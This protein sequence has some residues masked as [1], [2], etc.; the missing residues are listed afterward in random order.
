MFNKLIC[1]YLS[2][3]CRHFLLGENIRFRNRNPF[4]IHKAGD[5][6]IGD[7]VVFNNKTRQNPVGLFKKTSIFIGEDAS[8]TIGKNTG[9]SGVSI[10]CSKEIEI[11]SYCNIGGNVMIFDTDFHPLDYKARRIHKFEEIRSKGISIG[12]D[13]FIGANSII[14]KGVTIGNKSILGAGSVLTKN[15]PS[16]EIWGGNPARLIRKI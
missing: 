15:M 5:I 12:D 13:V 16:N 4:Y 1:I 10:Y 8:L 9:L 14:M 6:K 2:K 7:N 3:K 11:G